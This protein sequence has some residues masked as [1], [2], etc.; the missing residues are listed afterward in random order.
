M[1]RPSLLVPGCWFKPAIL[2]AASLALFV[3]LVVAGKSF[4][5]P[6]AQPAKT[7]P[8][9]DNHTDEKVTI[10]A[11]PYDTAEKAKIFSVDFLANGLLPVFFVITNDGDQPLSI[12][13]MQVTLITA[14]RSKMTP[15]ATE[16]LFPIP[17]KQVKNSLSRKQMDEIE[18]SQ[19]AAHAVEP[20]GTQSGFLFFDVQDV[21]APLAGSNIDITGVTDA[22]GTE[23]MYFE[24]GMDQYLKAGKQ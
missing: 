7:Y 12:A 16:D 15:I 4:V 18:A 22:K 19:F 23:L 3:P 2:I 21:A 1:W 6:V 24:I 10:A 13:N 17:R 9:H 8:A 5:K 20:H 14:H 11:E